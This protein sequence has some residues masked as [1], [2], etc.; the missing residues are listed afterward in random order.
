L[1]D[2]WTDPDD[3][4][5]FEMAKYAH[6]KQRINIRCVGLSTT[7][8]HGAG[9]VDTL[10][11]ESGIVAPIGVPLVSHVPS[12]TPPYQTAIRARGISQGLITGA[13][14]YTDAVAV[15]RQALVNT[16]KMT[17]IEIGYP[18]T[19]IEILQSPAD[20]IS[21][22]TGVELFRA[23]VRRILVMG[24]AYPS[25][26]ENNF[27]RT[28]QAITAARTLM[29]LSPVPVIYNGY[30]VGE[31]ILT[32]DNLAGQ[33]ASNYVA[34]ALQLSGDAAGRPSWDP[35]AMLLA[36]APSL[37]AAGF[38]RVRGKNAVDV[39]GANTFTPNING[40]DMYTVKNKTD[41]EF[42]AIINAMLVKANWATYDPFV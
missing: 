15:F 37:A 16:T 22:L 9:C 19:L 21:A 33:E 26:S 20:G 36:I 34:L 7:L 18:T 27:N 35:M 32:G 14:S 13:E 30:E 42:K 5:A 40:R 39:V 6:F 2:L 24:G 38:T 12:G 1:T 8:A 3:V 10:L 17:I 25:G 23:K 41:A 29:S 11:R 4:I 28:A 31:T